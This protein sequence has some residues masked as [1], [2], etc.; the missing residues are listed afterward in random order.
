MNATL[1]LDNDL[2]A[3]LVKVATADVE[4]A[5]VL[6]CSIFE[7]GTGELRVLG[8][9]LR[10]VPDSAYEERG[11]DFM[12][13]KSEGYVPA[14]GE[15]ETIGAS[16]IWL[17]THP[18]N[19][20]SPRPSR[21]DAKVDRDIADLFRIRTGSDYYGAVVVSHSAGEVTFMGHLETSTKRTSIGRLW[22]VGRRFSLVPSFDSRLPRLG[23]EFDRNVRA[24]GGAVQRV[25][26]DLRVGIVG[27]GGTGSA[28]AEQLVRLGVRR[29]HLAD[30]DK[31]TKSNVTRVYG[32][33][34]AD[35]GKKKV[36]VLASHLKQIAPQTH[37]EVDPTMIT[38]ERGARRLT[39]CDV[40]FGCTDD[41]AGRLVLSRL[42]TYFL[43]P[44]FDC[45]VLLSSDDQ[46]GWLTGIDGRVTTLVPGQACLVCRGRVDLQ[47]ANSEQLTPSERVR[48]VNEGYA[49]AL[50]GV[51]PAVVAYTSIVAS[52]AVGEL[53]ERLVG[54]GP[55]PA[56][57]EVLLRLHDREISTNVALPRERHYCHVNSKKIGRGMTDPFLEQTWP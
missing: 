54:F 5:G 28:V 2:E 7:T 31:L 13:I 34:P 51:E 38:L 20:S 22:S 25:L 47:R 17:H 8:R 56:P 18:G 26:S 53:L 30:P 36:D 42:A 33:T 52:I 46:R 16:A 57:S 21:H 45:G 1:V 55:D 23:N 12:S 35:I 48:L 40:I 19:N 29:F 39:S 14:L 43:I 11:C 24:F 15:A 49:P 41:N 3:E 32:S 27:C 6:L 4:S 9:G 44:V 37:V 50:G 10:W